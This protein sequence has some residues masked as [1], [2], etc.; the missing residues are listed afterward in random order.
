MELA[1]LVPIPVVLAC[2]FLV[3]Y[4]CTKYSLALT[5]TIGTTSTWAFVIAFVSYSLPYERIQVF[6]EYAF[7]YTIVV[8][9]FFFFRELHT[10]EFTE[11]PIWRRC[12]TVLMHTAVVGFIAAGLGNAI[13]IVT[14]ALMAGFEGIFQKFKKYLPR[15]DLKS[16]DDYKDGLNA[17]GLGDYKEAFEKLR[18]RAEHGDAMANT[19]IGEMYKNGRGVAQDYAES[20]K[21]YGRAAEE[22]FVMA[23]Y[24]LGTMYAGGWGVAKDYIQAYKWI[25]IAAAK[26][27]ESYR[28]GRD[29]LTKQMT[30]AQVAEAQKLA[31]E[32]MGEHNK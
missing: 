11:I 17:Y 31:R 18:P 24:R 3:G 21:W 4:V 23:Q 5:E 12:L 29:I 30:P 6:G 7:L 26:G 2:V 10:H 19:C 25:E 9:L 16:A 1:V 32:W 28:E 15:L 20:V 14:L 27:D 8:L 22:G 13:S